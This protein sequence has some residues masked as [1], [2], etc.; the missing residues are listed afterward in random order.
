MKQLSENAPKYQQQEE[1]VY[2]A[3]QIIYEGEISTRAGSP[4]SAPADRDAGIDLFG[5]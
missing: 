4:L 5:D 1:E 3:P 2:E